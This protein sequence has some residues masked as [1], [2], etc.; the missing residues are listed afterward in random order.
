M[1]YRLSKPSATNVS[2][3]RGNRI[4]PELRDSN[5]TSRPAAVLKPG[6]WRSNFRR[7]RAMASRATDGSNVSIRPGQVPNT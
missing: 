1:G 7:A 6:I 5:P 2:A 4:E 3:S